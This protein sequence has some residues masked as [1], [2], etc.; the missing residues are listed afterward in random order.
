MGSVPARSDA[1]QILEETLLCELADIKRSRRQAWAN[2]DL[3]RK[4]QH[5]G[6]YGESDAVEAAVLAQ[7]VRVLGY[8]DAVI[9]WRLLQPQLA[10]QPTGARVAVVYDLTAKEALLATTDGEIAAFARRGNLMRLVPLEAVIA[11]VRAAFARVRDAKVAR[12]RARRRPG[13]PRRR[14]G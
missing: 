5:G 10:G 2:D 9:A 13:A 8:D 12:D 1:I 14:S 3:L 6:K 11:D 4:A 7:L